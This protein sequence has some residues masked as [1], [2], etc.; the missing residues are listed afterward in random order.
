MKK[1]IVLILCLA[2]LLAAGCQKSVSGTIG[3][4]PVELPSVQEETPG[5]PADSDAETTEP[6]AEPSSVDET[7]SA[8]ESAPETEPAIG[9]EPSSEPAIE[10]EPS[11]DPAIG[12]E[13]STEPAIGTEPSTEPAIETEPS[14]EPAIETEPSTEPAIETEPETEPVI[15][16]EPETEPVIETEPETEPVI[17]TEPETEPVIETEPE[18]EPVTQPIIESDPIQVALVENMYAVE[19]HYVDRDGNEYDYSYYVPWFTHDTDAAEEMNRDIAETVLELV[20]DAEKAMEAQ[21]YLE[22]TDVSWFTVEYREIVSLIIYYDDWDYDWYQVYCYNARTCERMLTEDLLDYLVIGENEFLSYTKDY[23]A[24]IFDDNYGE[25]SD[26]IW[27]QADLYHLRQ[28]TIDWGTLDMM[29]FVTE[30]G[31]LAVIAEIGEPAGRG[32]GYSIF[33]PEIPFG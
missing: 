22:L 7:E 8:A 11:T 5:L 3:T 33:C 24:E 4:K 10:T 20:K 13:P 32:F 16:T 25:L 14:T 28:N 2:L 27:E 30:D 19:G 1:G 18:T 6:G 9:T 26:E 31:R 23:V 21:E 29:T 17:E 12:T 15:E